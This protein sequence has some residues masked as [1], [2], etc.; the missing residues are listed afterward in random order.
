[1]NKKYVT[2]A[3][4]LI[5]L[6]IIGLLLM[7]GRR[8]RYEGDEASKLLSEIN[9]QL[10][11]TSTLWTNIKS[12]LE[13][14]KI[15]TVEDDISE[16][17]NQI[18]NAKAAREDI[19]EIKSDLES[20]RNNQDKINDALEEMEQLEL[21]EWIFD[22]IELQKERNEKDQERVDKTDN[23]LTKL[24]L[25]YAYSQEFYEA[26]IAEINMEANLEEGI[27]EFLEENIASAREQF[28]EAMDDNSNVKKC[29]EAASKII[30][31]D[32][33]EKAS[34]NREDAEE[35]IRKLQEV[36]DLAE[37]G[38]YGEASNLFQEADKEYQELRRLYPSDLMPEHR[39]WWSKNVD[40][41]INDLRDLSRVIEDIESQVK[42][43]IKEHSE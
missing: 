15:L 41:S 25:Y 13:D 29:I 37:K 39:E 7:R 30:S 19:N 8:D 33:L 21:P 35:I 27:N 38:S 12:N 10:Q 31:F 18:D 26:K 36:C 22:Y 9:D 6:A 17:S 20:I 11:S 28:E 2:I 3:A 34:S 40:S 24:D 14:M 5:F 43:L 32:Y 42:S 23:M 4:I 1:M 16:I